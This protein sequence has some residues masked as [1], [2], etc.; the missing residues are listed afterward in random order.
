MVRKSTTP[1]SH[2]LVV[3]LHPKHDHLLYH[4]V[5]QI[6]KGQLARHVKLA[7][8]EYAQRYGGRTIEMAPPPPP[9][10]PEQLVVPSL[11]SLQSPPRPTP[12]AHPP[13]GLPAQSVPTPQPVS[14]PAPPPAPSTVS[15]APEDDGPD[16]DRTISAA[17]LDAMRR[18]QQSLG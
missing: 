16:G 9:P 18:L 14:A 11:D 17:D 1:Q 4:W 6:P 8:L 10:P 12:S 5:K 15:D 7:L 13:A 3:S 2:R